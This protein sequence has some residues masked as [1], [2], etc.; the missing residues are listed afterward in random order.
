[1]RRL[2]RF[3]ARARKEGA[4]YMT[5]DQYVAYRQAHHIE[6]E[7]HGILVREYDPP[8]DVYWPSWAAWRF[9]QV[10][11]ALVRHRDV[12]AQHIYSA[13]PH[14]YQPLTAAY[15]ETVRDMFRGGI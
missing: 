15:K 1:M 5:W 8:A 6:P 10:S 9:A 3:F 4:H 12:E 13:E 14:N 11:P 2:R 7:L